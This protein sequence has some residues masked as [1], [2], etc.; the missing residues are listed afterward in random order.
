M[1]KAQADIEAKKIFEERN[2]KADEIIKKAKEDGIWLTGLDSNKGLF[3]EL[4]KETKQ[5]LKE[6]A[7]MIDEE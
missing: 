7:A 6:L 5:K 2:R 3:K 4:D 1:K